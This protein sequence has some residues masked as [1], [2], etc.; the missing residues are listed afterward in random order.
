METH[1]H[2]VLRNAPY[3]CEFNPIEHIWSSAKT[4]FNKLIVQVRDHSTAAV[5]QTWAKALD[6]IPTETWPNCVAHCERI[7]REAF[8]QERLSL[9]S[10]LKIVV[11][12]M[13]SSEES[14]SEIDKALELQAKN[15]QAE[16]KRKNL[17]LEK[18]EK[19]AFL[20]KNDYKGCLILIVP[21]RDG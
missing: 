4:S 6:G 1:G 3:H 21:E 14:E 7:M 17:L 5:I 12:L 9:V 10:P 8:E 11:S 18:V 16:M 15:E 19:V 20:K 13:D 2:K